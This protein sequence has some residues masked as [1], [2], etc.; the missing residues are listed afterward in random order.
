MPIPIAPVDDL[1]AIASALRHQSIWLSRIRTELMML[2][3]EGSHEQE[4]HEVRK[5]ILAILSPPDED[6]EAEAQAVRDEMPDP[7]Q[8][9]H[10][11]PCVCMACCEMRR[12]AEV[13]AT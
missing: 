4:A 11:S 2:A 10:P 8:T 1:E 12:L 9:P 3:N 5:R 6:A 13:A 7:F